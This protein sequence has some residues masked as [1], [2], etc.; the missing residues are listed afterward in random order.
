MPENPS[1]RLSV[2]VVVYDMAREAPRTL[3]SLSTA[4]QRGVTAEDYEVLVVENGS[5]EPLDAAR[6]EAL[7]GQ[8]RYFFLDDAPPSPAHAVNF[9][10]A[11]ARGRDVGVLIDGARIA[12]PGMLQS[13]LAAL[14]AFPRPVVGTLAFHLGPDFQTRSVA[15]GYDS[16][17][18]DA[19]LERID[20]RHD[21]Y[22]LFEISAFAGS[23]ED[24]WFLPL[25][26]SNAVFL[27]KRLYA[28]L[29]GF[30]ETFATPGGGLVNLDFY[31]RACEL[32][33]SELVTLLGEAT[34]HQ[35]HGGAMTNRPPEE[36]ARLWE[37]LVEEYRRIRGVSFRRPERR[38]LF[39][40]EV[41]PGVVPWLLK[42]CQLHLERNADERN[43]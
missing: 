2:V 26:E 28:E 43:P 24:G 34:F 18:E 4:F 23:S 35:V 29:G 8:F 7:D 40:G 10:V 20:W 30:E 32:P 13:A 1:P 37:L 41:T 14:G 17:Q 5:P 39:F 15:Q 11:R 27:P 42:S 36:A 3:Y 16:R 22:R 21:G 6:V 25:A 19:L 12:S 31:R 33:G 38:A 9:G